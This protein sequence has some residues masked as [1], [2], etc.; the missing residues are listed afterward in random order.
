MRILFIGGT[1]YLGRHLVEQAVAR[2]HEVTIFHRGQTNRGLFPGIDERIGDRDGG[3]DA[4]KDDFW[5]ACVDTCGYFPR[6]V[7]ASAS[8]LAGSVIHYTFVSSVS[9]Y[10]DFT[11]P[12]QD[13]SSPVGTL[14]DP[15]VEEIT[16]DTYGPLKALCEQAAE[17]ELPGG[18]LNVRA[19]L[20]VGPFDTS[21]RFTYWPT[22]VERGGTI[23][24]PGSPDR[25]VQ[26][27]DVRDLSR[28][29]L[30]RIE[31]ATTGTFNV[32]GLAQPLSMKAFLES[33]IQTIGSKAELRWVGDDLLKEAGVRAYT[34]MPLW[35]P[36][37]DDSFDC[38]RAIE[39][40]LTFRPIADTIRDTLAWAK[41]R[42]AD[43][44]WRN[45]LSPEREAELLAKA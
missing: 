38:R 28:W 4:L 12:N 26:V 14:D 36:D 39:L 17:D 45:G 32:T 44:K 33:C 13:E 43:H 7:R 22:R 2:G 29:I 18:V 3:L 10:K 40:G 30:E 25:L 5:D 9:V 37:M 19:G 15:K 27:I 24:A 34:E 42:P 31:V 20:I 21:D 6:L 23:L 1:L 8:F 16:N 35:I 11:K 41:T